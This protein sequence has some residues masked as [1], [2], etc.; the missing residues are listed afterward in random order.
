[1]DFTGF[2]RPSKT[3]SFYEINPGRAKHGLGHPSVGFVLG[4]ILPEILWVGLV[5]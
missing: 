5:W 3:F 1:M 4:L 2:L